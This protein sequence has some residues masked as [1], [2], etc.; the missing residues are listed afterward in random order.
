MRESRLSGSEGG[1]A[2]RGHPYPYGR[3][4]ARRYGGTVGEGK[5]WM[6]CHGARRP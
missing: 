6:I 2:F 5:R 1:V 3:R 4:D